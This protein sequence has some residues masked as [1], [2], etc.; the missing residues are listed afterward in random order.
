MGKL[1]A[2]K[3]AEAMT[4]EAME[5]S[6][7]PYKIVHEGAAFY[8]PKMDFQIY[9][10]IGRVFTASTNQLDLYMGKAFGLE[11]VD[12]DG[13][14]KTPAIIH[15]APLGTHERFIGFLVEHFAGNFPLWLSPTQVTIIPI[16]EM[17]LDYALRLE[18]MLVDNDIRIELDYSKDGF[19]KRIRAAK[20]SKVPYF[21]VIGDKDIEAGMLTL[22]SRDTGNL[23]Q[24][25]FDQ[26]LEKLQTEI[27]NKTA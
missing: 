13:L 26:V 22:E 24:F 3:N 15:R 21:I 17:H 10:S 1:Q 12:N 2:W 14:R 7:V 6:G 5:R 27:K 25:T 16:A 20:S 11:Y 19:G 8:G 18:K 23:G 9:S 4:I